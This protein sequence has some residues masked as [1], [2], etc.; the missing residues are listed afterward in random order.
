MT[1]STV[2][3][4]FPEDGLGQ[5]VVKCARRSHVVREGARHPARRLLQRRH[6]EQLRQAMQLVADASVLPEGEFSHIYTSGQHELPD[7]GLP[8]NSRWAEK[9]GCGARRK[10][11]EIVDTRAGYIYDRR[12]QPNPNPVWGFKARPG[13]AEMFIYPDCKDGRVVADVIRID[14]GHTEGLEPKVTEEIIKLMLSAKGGKIQQ[15]R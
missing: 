4:A 10:P 2:G 5:S 9:L 3:L 7:S 8:G 13:K 11:Q 12:E 15:S 6:R 1:E 14:K